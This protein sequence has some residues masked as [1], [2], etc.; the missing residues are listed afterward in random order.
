MKEKLLKN[1]GQVVSIEN[2]ANYHS[3]SNR[4]Q[5]SFAGKLEYVKDSDEFYVRVGED[6]AAGSMGISFKL[7]HVDFLDKRGNGELWIILK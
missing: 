6:Y 7:E 1:V 3:V 2:A 4:M 5:F